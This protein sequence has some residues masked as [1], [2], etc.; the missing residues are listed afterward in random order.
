MLVRECDAYKAYCDL[1]YYTDKVPLR[2]SK[3]KKQNIKP[4]NQNRDA[5]SIQ[6]EINELR[7]YA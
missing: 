5:E 3:W 1:C 7:E 4:A 2:K 6:K